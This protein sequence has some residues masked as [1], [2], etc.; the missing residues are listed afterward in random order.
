M[1]QI[2]P[3]GVIS[4]NVWSALISLANLVLLYFLLKRFL[5]KPVHKVLEA[6]QAHVDS[7]YAEAEEARAE[8]EGDR[9]AWEEK[10]QGVRAEAEGIVNRANER[11]RL[12]S[13]AML[14]EAKR[15]AAGIVQQALEEAQL[16]RKQAEASM[17]REMADVST[18][19]AGKLL[20]RE[21][22]ENDHRQFIDS[23]IEELGET[24]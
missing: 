3:L 12:N 5:F 1:P 21:I 20:G 23:F 7:V 10:M 19:L 17:R 8:A 9:T 11:A 22:N 16:T 2:Q 6:R 14:D 18:E 13:D 24:R 15:R 4:I